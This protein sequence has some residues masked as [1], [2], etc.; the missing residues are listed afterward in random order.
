MAAM[1]PY[2]TWRAE[3][4]CHSHRQVHHINLGLQQMTMVFWCVATGWSWKLR[5]FLGA[6]RVETESR[7]SWCI[8]EK[9]DRIFQH[10]EDIFINK[11]Q[12]S[13][14]ITTFLRWVGQKPSSEGG[15]HFDPTQ[16]SQNPGGENSFFK[17]GAKKKDKTMGVSPLETRYRQGRKWGSRAIPAWT[18][19]RSFPCSFS[20]SEQQSEAPVELNCTGWVLMISDLFGAELMAFCWRDFWVSN[21]PKFCTC[22]EFGEFVIRIGLPRKKKTHR[23]SVIGTTRWASIIWSWSSIP[24]HMSRKKIKC[25]EP[26]AIQWIQADPSEPQKSSD[27]RCSDA[28]RETILLHGRE[29]LV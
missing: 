29:P 21:F 4:H 7:D 17:S 16:I 8:E 24:L 1:G 12:L 22:G 18:R 10:L 15:G 3:C 11:H 9:S 28:S 6:N 26:P 20:L 14:W 13:L 25:H 19:C 27:S 23:T 5:G 2:G